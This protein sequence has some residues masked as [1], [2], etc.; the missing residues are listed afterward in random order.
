VSRF[1]V[2]FAVV[3]EACTAAFMR[4]ILSAGVDGLVTPRDV[5]A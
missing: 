4:S 2:L 1:A 5:P 3:A